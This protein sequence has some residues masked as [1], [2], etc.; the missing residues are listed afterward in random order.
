MEPAQCSWHFCGADRRRRSQSRLKKGV[1]TIA[2]NG[3]EMAYQY[4]ADGR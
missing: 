4:L 2:K 3:R 1:S